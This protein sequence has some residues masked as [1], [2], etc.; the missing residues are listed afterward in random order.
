MN[1][2]VAGLIRH[3]LTTVGGVLVAKG[4]LEAGVL[5]G[6]IGAL[7]TLIGTGW[8]IWVKVVA[9]RGQD[10][11]APR[12]G[13][14]AR[15]SLLVPLAL[16]V[17]LGLSGCETVKSMADPLRSSASKEAP[18]VAAARTVIDEGYALLTA[19]NKVIGENVSAGVWSKA[20]AQDYLD[21]SREMRIRLDSA[22][23]MLRAGDP[24]N[25]KN[26]AELIRTAILALQKRIAADARKGA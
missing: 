26:Q 5:E 17:V 23:D 11:A 3:T 21:R 9:A 2:Q 6:V 25:A 7:M 4:Y 24:L 8:S 22:R 16:A 1:D 14:W 19:V 18:A 12:Q 10:A 15:V 20:Q 13:G